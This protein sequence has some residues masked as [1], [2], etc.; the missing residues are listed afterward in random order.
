MVKSS[1]KTLVTQTQNMFESPKKRPPLRAADEYDF[2]LQH[3]IQEDGSHYY[4]AQDWIMGVAQAADTQQAKDIFQKFKKRRTSDNLALVVLPYLSPNGR[5]YQMEF[6]SEKTL[7]TLTQYIQANTGIRNA[8]LGFLA[9]AGVAVGD[10]E[11]K[12]QAADTQQAKLSSQDKRLLKDKIEQGYSEDEAKTFIE[13]VK[14]GK[15][16]RKDWTAVLKLV[17]RGAINYAL[18]TNVEYT[19]VFNMT[20]KQIKAATG[21]TVARDG[22]TPQGRAIM[23]AVELSLE[24]ALNARGE[25]TFKEACLIT[26]NVCLAYGGTVKNL[27]AMMGISIATGLPLMGAGK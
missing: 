11:Q 5:T 16:K 21:F 6:V 1:T 18:I 7:Y 26:E 22:M 2:P 13:L 8:V 25:C 23:T 10:A 4:S 27:E 24:A 12:A 17:V 9:D 20:A 19:S 3:Y 15:V 14:E